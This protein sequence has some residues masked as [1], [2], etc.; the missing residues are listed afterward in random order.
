MSEKEQM[1]SLHIEGST[2][3]N[4]DNED[5]TR[6]MIVV[7]DEMKYTNPTA[8]SGGR[9]YAVWKRAK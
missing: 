5:Q 1:V 8:S 6:V 4:W 9:N 3:P 2:F 7:G